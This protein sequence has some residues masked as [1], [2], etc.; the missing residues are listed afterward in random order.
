M[1]VVG[2]IGA[3]VACALRGSLRVAAASIP[4]YA[5]NPK[6]ATATYAQVHIERAPDAAGSPGAFTEIAS[7]AIDTLHE[8]TLY[9]DGTG[10]ITS[11]Y[12]HRYETTAGSGVYSDYSDA[13][14][15]GD[16]I[17][18]QR[19]KLDIPASDVASSDWDRWTAESLL[20]MYHN[21]IWYP[22]RV[23]IT[24]TTDTNQNVI[25]YYALDQRIR[26]AYAIELVDPTSGLHIEWIDEGPE[27]MQ[28]GG[29]VRLFGADTQY[30]YLVHGK[31]IFRNLGELLDDYF[32]VMQA[33][34]ALKYVGFRRKQREDFIAY[35]VGDPRTDTTWRD[36]L[37]A[38]HEERADRD[39]LIAGARNPEP[40]IAW[41]FGR[42]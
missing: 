5:A 10:T 6:D 12:R 29:Q 16:S 3:L 30:N 28:E 2:L 1:S 20:E 38:E 41:S 13:I 17:V 15:A 33:F 22:L 27:W 7:V 37:A 14:Q 23:T 31:A 40:A 35:M 24:P 34:L 9:S 36:L 4:Y 11:W 42:T 21:G 39:A 32:P 25:E 26:E 18:R 8:Y 19:I